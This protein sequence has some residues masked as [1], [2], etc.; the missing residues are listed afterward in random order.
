M[1]GCV[2]MSACACSREGH[3]K[4][5]NI[6]GCDWSVRLK[7]AGS[8]RL[9]Y[10]LL[11]FTA[12]ATTKA[13]ATQGLNISPL[14]LPHSYFHINA[15]KAKDEISSH[16]YFS[17]EGLSIHVRLGNIITRGKN[18]FTS[19]ESA[20]FKWK[21]FKMKECASCVL[22]ASLGAVWS[23]LNF[24]SVFVCKS[25]CMFG[26]YSSLCKNVCF[27]ILKNTIFL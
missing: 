23:K 10:C 14:Q 1:Q 13:T 15:S 18:T 12:A 16:T 25:A 11:Q 7:E 4:K 3:F 26:A 19:C 22:Y 8:H 2:C 6:A 27:P 24:S 21:G 9:L 5:H 17:A 20:V